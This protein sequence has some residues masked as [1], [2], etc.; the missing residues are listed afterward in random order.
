MQWLYFFS[1]FLHLLAAIIWV[2]GM[3]FLVIIVVPALRR[4][5]FGGIAAALVRWSGMRFRRVGWICFGVLF[6]T[7]VANLLLRGIGWRELQSGE[8]WQ[9]AFGYTLMIKLSLAAA[10]LAVS[11]IHDFFVGPRAAAAWE[12]DP[13]AKE[14]RRLRRWA[15]HLGRLNLLL[16]LAVI[17]L[18]IMLVR[19]LA[20]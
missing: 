11:A 4:P 8:F 6:A 9:G 14:T 15:V 7:G 17:A 18:A 19:G 16:A 2:G 12:T 5:E 3:I 10:I 13:A 20:I 1:V